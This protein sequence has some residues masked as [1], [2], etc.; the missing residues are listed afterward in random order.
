SIPPDWAFD[1]QGQPTTD[2]HAALDGFIRPLGG[3]KGAALALMVEL[4]SAAF[5]GS[6][7]A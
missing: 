1:T 7:F 6:N 5:T 2:P 3:S 4:L